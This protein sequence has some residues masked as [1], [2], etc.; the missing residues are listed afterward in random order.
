MVPKIKTVMRYAIDNNLTSDT[1]MQLTTNGTKFDN[2]WAEILSKFKNVRI[3]LSVDGIDKKAEYIRYG[4]K[5]E[6]IEKNI[7]K[8]KQLSNVNLFIHT[9]VSNLNLLSLSEIIQ[10][11]ID[12]NH[13]F[14]FD[15]V[16]Y[17]EEF[18]INNLPPSLIQLARERLLLLKGKHPSIND[19]LLIIDNIQSTYN[20]CWKKFKQEIIMR[21]KIRKNNILDINSE[22]ITYWYD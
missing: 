9:T 12:H 3:Q 13:Y 7:T 17:P 4:S 21:D 15:T 18:S 16:T 20:S 1:I 8:M 2:E 6:Q 10:W 22:F 11:C 19:L 5:W 14:Q